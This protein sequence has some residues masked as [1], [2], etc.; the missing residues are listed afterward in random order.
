MSRFWV[1]SNGIVIMMDGGRG[2]QHQNW[3]SG[4]VGMMNVVVDGN[5]GDM[6]VQGGRVM[7][8]H[9]MLD[10]RQMGKAVTVDLVVFL[11]DGM[12]GAVVGHS[13]THVVGGGGD[14]DVVVSSGHRGGSVVHQVG[15]WRP[16]GGEQGQGR[17]GR[18]VV[19]RR[20]YVVTLKSGGFW[21]CISLILH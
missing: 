11:V 19:W 8:H 10:H 2:R 6:M 5:R 12:V 4:L 21:K 14:G 3:S 1:S 18:N 16:Q 7:V 17:V 13:V 9:V 20:K 15:R